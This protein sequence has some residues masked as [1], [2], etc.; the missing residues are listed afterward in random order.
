MTSTEP[1]YNKDPNTR[2]LV[3]S[4]VVRRHHASRR[5]EW[6]KKETLSKE[7]PVPP[8]KC[9]GDIG[10]VAHLRRSGFQPDAPCL[11]YGRHQG[12]VTSEISQNVSLRLNAVVTEVGTPSYPEIG[13]KTSGSPTT[14]LG[15]GT[16]DPLMSYPV[17]ATPRI[18]I[19]IDHCKNWSQ[20][21]FKS[22]RSFA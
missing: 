7:A 1:D 6:E 10:K 16:N 8:C 19:L 22:G 15:A 20:D 18:N 11:S 3:R 21:S 13:D 12:P 2:K 4:H 17:P 9:I 5:E 14:L